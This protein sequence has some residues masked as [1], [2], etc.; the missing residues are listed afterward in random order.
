M[1]FTFEELS[2]SDEFN[3]SS[4]YCPQGNMFCRQPWIDFV[5]NNAGGKFIGVKITDDSLRVSFFAGILF[6]KFGK[7]NG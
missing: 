6:K 1:I 7:N 3:S 4:S 2:S 5:E